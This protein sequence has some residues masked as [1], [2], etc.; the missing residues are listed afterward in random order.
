M[1]HNPYNREHFTN[2]I[3]D[4]IENNEQNDTTWSEVS[5]LLI[6]CKYQQPKHVQA[7][8]TNKLKIFSLNIRSLMK[9]IHKIRE[10]ISIYNKYDILAFNETNCIVDKL[11]HKINDLLLEGFHEPFIQPPTRA[12]GKG[13]GLATYINKRVCDFLA[14]YKVSI[15][16][17]TLTIPVVSSNFLNYITVRVIIALKL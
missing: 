17:L 1:I 15:H 7:P 3:G 4:M 9:N 12:S 14:N 6:K 11:P 5:D 10:D 16:I 8:S 13:G 2:L